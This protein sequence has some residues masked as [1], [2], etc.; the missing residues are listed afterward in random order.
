[1]L[2]GDNENSLRT[3]GSSG[4]DGGFVAIQW[5]IQGA[6]SGMAPIQL[7]RLSNEEVNMRHWET[8]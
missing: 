5:R 3:I 6:N 4:D 1:L 8:Y 7:A 2:Y